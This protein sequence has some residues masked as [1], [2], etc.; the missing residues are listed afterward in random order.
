MDD[1]SDR[2]GRY[3]RI[4]GLDPG[5]PD[6]D[7]LSR[8]VRAHL[9]R[10][11]FENVSKLYSVRC[12]GL[13]EPPGLGRFL[14]G[15]ETHRFGGTCYSNSPHLFSLLRHLGFEA[16]LCG[17]DMASGPDV[18][19]VIFVRVRERD[20]LVDVGYGAPFFEP[21]PRDLDS[22][23]VVALGRDRFVLRPRD[24][25]GRS[26]MD[27]F[28]EG[29]LIHGYLAKP[30]ARTLDHFET[31]VL[32]SYAEEATFMNALVAVRFLEDRS[33]AIYN[34]QFVVNS[35]EGWD[36]ST[37]PDPESR[38]DAV[39]E[40]FGIPGE[41]VREAIAGLDFLRGI[42]GGPVAGES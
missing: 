30:A 36:V 8:I 15:I 6:L 27:H 14:D 22:D 5:P 39:I 9:T 25:L 37:L 42:H 21:L 35:R 13:R 40:H 28:R 32:D 34:D 16:A 4:L 31:V 17:A 23:H 12:L 33:V 29:K 3:L 11:P 18:H 38:A 2:F 26:R 24:D 19:V 20:Y 41:I 10:V 7:L 1:D